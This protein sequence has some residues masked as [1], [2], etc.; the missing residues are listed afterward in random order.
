MVKD[1]EIDVIYGIVDS[2]RQS[3]KSFAYVDGGCVA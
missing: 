2:N 3:E 1:V